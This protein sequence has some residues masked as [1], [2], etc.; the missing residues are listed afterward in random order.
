MVK[1]RLD[2]SA[3]AAEAASQLWQWENA[4]GD[5]SRANR[6]CL[7]R[8]ARGGLR[9]GCRGQR[10]TRGHHP[11]GAPGRDRR[12]GDGVSRQGRGRRAT[13]ALPDHPRT[14]SA[15]EATGTGADMTVAHDETAAG[16]GA[17]ET[18]C[19]HLPQTLG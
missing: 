15:A 16:R 19:S 9:I 6:S 11:A 8:F 2:K 14:H 1:D 18:V 12:R 4:N 5:N 10:R 3:V 13:V 7:R 17:T